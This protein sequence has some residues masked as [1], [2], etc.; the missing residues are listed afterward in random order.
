MARTAC[1]LPVGALRF[2]LVWHRVRSGNDRP[3]A[4]CGQ[5]ATRR[6]REEDSIGEAAVGRSER[7]AATWPLGREPHVAGQDAANIWTLERIAQVLA[8]RSDDLAKS[9]HKKHSAAAALATHPLVPSKLSQEAMS[10]SAQRWQRVWATH[11]R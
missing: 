6:V 9:F 10:A 4:G 8:H 3:R 5:R 11:E 2:F 7:A 1:R